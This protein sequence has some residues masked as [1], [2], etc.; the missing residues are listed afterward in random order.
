MHSRLLHAGSEGNN[1][2]I[3]MLTDMVVGDCWDTQR[4]LRW[5]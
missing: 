4:A 3:S 5:S 2:K 1:C